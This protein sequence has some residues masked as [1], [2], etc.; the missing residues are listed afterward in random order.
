MYPD[1]ATM[2]GFRR[3]LTLAGPDSEEFELSDLLGRGAFGEVYLAKGKRSGRVLAVK[4]IPIEEL[5]DATTRAALLHEADAATQVVHPNVVRVV[6]VEKVGPPDVGPYLMME[7]VTGGTLKKLLA[8]QRSANSP[9]PLD[10]AMQMMTDIAQ[11]AKAINAVLVHRDI[12]PDNVLVDGESLKIG[13]LGISKLVQERTRTH[14]FKGGQ[15]IRYMAPEGW[16]SKDNSYKLDVYSVGLVFAEILTLEHPLEAAVKDRSDWREWRK[17]HLFGTVPDLRTLRP[18]ISRDL[19][20]LVARMMAKRSQD[21]PEW[22]EVLSRLSGLQKAE[23]TR[24]ELEP[25]LEAAFNLEKKKVKAA[26]D[27]AEERDRAGRQAEFY[28]HSCEALVRELDQVA[29]TFNEK[30]QGATIEVQK[31]ENQRR[32]YVVPNQVGIE[33]R[34]FAQGPGTIRLCGG[35]LTGGAFLGVSHPMGLSGNFLRV[36][37]GENDLYGEWRFCFTKVHALVGDPR[38]IQSKYSVTAE[39]FGFR[40]HDHFFDEIQWAG[41]GGMHIFTYEIVSATAAEVMTAMLTNAF[42]VKV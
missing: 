9:V 8:D 36:Q 4:L 31:G 12:K 18:E 24:V 20:H 16:E 2:A 38:E 11:G 28:L 19:A 15:Q 41:Q 5:E 25:A 39:P 37:M 7:Y 21:R 14:T 33:L 1:A 32:L 30:T 23:D 3:G 6:H 29:E 35:T 13:D 42:K 17:A 10:R 40:R 27:I 34:F 26:L 22:D